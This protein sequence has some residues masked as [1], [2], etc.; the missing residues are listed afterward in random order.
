M[1]DPVQLKILTFVF[2]K[3]IFD[4]Q[5]LNQRSRNKGKLL[6]IF[7]FTTKI[8]SKQS[9]RTEIFSPKNLI[10]HFYSLVLK[11]CET[12]KELTKKL[13]ISEECFRQVF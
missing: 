8:P 6:W 10:Y 3:M 13:K 1:G 9:K 4:F 12:R 5:C 2:F 11:S 7:Y